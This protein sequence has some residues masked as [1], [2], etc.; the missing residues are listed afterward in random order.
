[1]ELTKVMTQNYFPYAKYTI[2]S[3]AIPSIDGLKPVQRRILYIMKDMGLLGDNNAKSH[4]ID[5]QVMRLHPNGDSSIYEALVLMSS[6]YEGLNVPY[7][8]SKGNFGKK[9]SRDMQYAASRYTEARLEPI[10]SELFDGIKEDAVDFVD[11]FDG[12]EKEPTLLP[13]KFPTILVNSNN[14]VAVGKSSNIPFFSLT[15]VCK[16][17]KGILTGEITDAA[18]LSKVLGVPEFTTGGFIHASDASLEKLCA[19]GKGS[20]VISGHVERYSNRIVID[21]IPYNTTAEDIIEAAEEKIKDGTIRGIKEIRDDTDLKYGLRVTIE[22]KNGYDSKEILRQLCRY[23]PIRKY[24]SFR[25]TVIIGDRCVDLSILDLLKE[26]IKFRE[27]C[28]RRTYTFRLDKDTQKAHML[29]TWEK[30][31][32]NIPEVVQMISRNTDAVAKQNLINNYGLVDDQAEY[33]LEM[34]IRSITTDRADKALKELDATR[35]RI[36]YASK[37]LNGDSECNKIIVDDMDYIIDKYGKQN[38]TGAA[39]ELTE[40]DTKEPEVKISDENVVVVVTTDGY[41]KR[42]VTLTDMA[43]KYVNGDQVEKFRWGVKNNDYILVFDRYGAVHKVLVDDIDSSRGALKEKLF[44][45]AN[46][47]KPEDMIWADAAGDYSGYFNLVYANGKGERVY[48][49]SA[50]G[51]RTQYKS[52]YNEV[53]PGRYWITTENQFFIITHRMKAA[54]C[55]ITQLGIL[56]NR[57][58]FKI[59]KISSGDWITNLALYKDVPSKKL[60]NLDRYKKDYT[61]TIG[62]DVLWYDEELVARAQKQLELDSQQYDEAEKAEGSE[63]SEADTEEGTENSVEN[64]ETET[65]DN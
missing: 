25:T 28:I 13:V 19:T 22:L 35:D 59:A 14:G 62:D 20:F 16:A 8:L 26:W 29:E 2:I 51:K 55:D 44:S 42:L 48:Y 45:K 54:F 3:R 57:S 6:G 33:L 7:V 61:V 23:T 31:K 9:Y 58:A 37:V 11:N 63:E 47:E 38:R 30:I 12:T 60:I 4:R 39:P 10:C 32:N 34:K 49:N 15:N 27:T 65:S 17:T 21:Q 24:I 43:K 5:G 40:E 64:T 36:A 18:G 53:E 41:I 46:L 1:M 50:V 56:S 52:L